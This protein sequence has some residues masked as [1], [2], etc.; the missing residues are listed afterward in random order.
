MSG[1]CSRAQACLR[2]KGASEGFC[3]V[4]RDAKAHLHERRYFVE[5]LQAVA[6]SRQARVSFMSGDV[7]VAAV[8][9][10]YSRPKVGVLG[11]CL[12]GRRVGQKARRICVMPAH[13]SLVEG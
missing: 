1:F 9:R 8:G 6:R 12:Q 5:R 10:F 2:A 4:R 11:A 13:A 3:D 7:H